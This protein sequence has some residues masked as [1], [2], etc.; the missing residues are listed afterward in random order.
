MREHHQYINNMNINM[1]I[2]YEYHQQF[3]TTSP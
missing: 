2:E 3:E 1:N